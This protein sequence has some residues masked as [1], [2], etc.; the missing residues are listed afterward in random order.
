M[1]LLFN[2]L[3]AFE[4]NQGV[5]LK[6]DPLSSWAIV[7]TTT[8][9]CHTC[10]LFDKQR[11]NQVNVSVIL[12]SYWPI[13]RSIQENIRTEVLKYGPNE[14]RSVRKADH[15]VRIFSRMGRTNWPKR[16]SLYS[17]NQRP[18]TKA[19]SKFNTELICVFLECSCWKGN[20]FQ[21]HISVKVK[22]SIKK[23]KLAW[24]FLSY[25]LLLFIEEGLRFPGPI[26][27]LTVQYGFGRTAN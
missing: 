14:V 11:K 9:A 20:C 17:H 7:L 23:V 2:F 18:K 21:F 5:T 19:F 12:C 6:C 15:E 8:H 10:N 4:A 27:L 13:V 3:V 16:A 24:K 25:Y 26:R 1:G 22:L